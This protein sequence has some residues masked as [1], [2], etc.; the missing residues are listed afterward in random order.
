MKHNKGYPTDE[1]STK[2]KA[3]EFDTQ[4]DNKEND[5]K[6]VHFHSELINE[7][8]GKLDITV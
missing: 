7:V 4:S 2:S 8:I 5:G 3:T 1:Q 6:N